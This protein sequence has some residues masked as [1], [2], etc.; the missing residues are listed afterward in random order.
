VNNRQSQNQNSISNK[1]N[2]TCE[3]PSPLIIRP[4]RPEDIPLIAQL[5]EEAFGGNK[6]ANLI[7]VLREEGTLAISLVAERSGEIVGH[8]SFS[9]MTIAQRDAITPAIG[10]APLAVRPEHQKQGAGSAV[11]REGVNAARKAGW[12]IVIVL[13]NPAYYGKF[14]FGPASAHGISCKEREAGAAFQVME[15]QPGA[16]ASVRGVADYHSAFKRTGCI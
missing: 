3:S 9:P 15:L 8:V 12:K 7:N 5:N 6:T 16:L 2:T 14:G 10:L 4:E 13:G 11:A 1:A